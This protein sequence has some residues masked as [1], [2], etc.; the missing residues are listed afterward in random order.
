MKLSL[1]QSRQVTLES[2]KR[3]ELA[4][5]NSF[6]LSVI[7][8]FRYFAK[9]N[10]KSWKKQLIRQGKNCYFPKGMFN[11]RASH[12]ILFFQLY[13]IFKCLSDKMEMLCIC[14]CGVCVCVCVRACMRA[15]VCVCVRVCVYSCVYVFGGLGEETPITLLVTVVWIKTVLGKKMHL[16]TSIIVFKIFRKRNVSASDFFFNKLCPFCAPF[17]L[18]FMI[19][20]ALKMNNLNTLSYELTRYHIIRQKLYNVT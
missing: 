16:L 17:N 14:M 13:I 5:Q 7:K 1:K 15:C 3:N 10:L 9:L 19:V 6:R 11:L 2:H 18:A 8:N 4:R 12:S 20:I